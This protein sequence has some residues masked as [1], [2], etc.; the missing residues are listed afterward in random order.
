MVYRSPIA[1]GI[2]WYEATVAD[3]PEY[4]R[5]YGSRTADVAIVGGGFTGLQ[6]A[7]RLAE[8]G[9]DVVLID[10]ARFGDGASGR[11]GGQLGT[12]HRTWPEDHAQALGFAEAK[13]LFRL[14]EDAKAHLLDFARRH[15][16]EIDYR[17]GQMSVVHKSRYVDD[18]RRH[19]DVMA[20]RYDY[21]HIRFMDREETARRLGSDRYLAGIRDTGTGHI[22]PLKLLVGTARAAAQ[23]GAALH[24]HTP[25][26]EIRSERGRVS[27]ATPA[28]TIT[29]ERA[30]VA[31]NAYIGGLEPVTAAH[32]MPIRSFI[33]AT[34]P[35][36]ESLGVLPGGESV[37]DSRFVVRYFRRS[38][39]GRLLFGGREAYTAD[40]PRDISRHIG[41]QI[42]EL[43]PALAE[44]EITHA[45]GGSVG[46]TVPREPFVR[47]VMPGVTSIGGFSG[48]GVMLSNYTGR[49]YGES[50][51]G[52]RDLLEP[53]KALDIP[54]FPGG[55]RFAKP[56]L[57]LAMT[58]FALRDRF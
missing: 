38:I 40:N 26:T 19:A 5:L 56:L 4:G 10:A 3:R 16:I 44:V 50:L 49:L 51:L 47:E 9:A 52:N 58:W 11:N 36:E 7:C 23:A 28:G 8:G 43:Y 42:G 17:P 20:E 39:D 18:Y 25:A 27:V 22:H 15:A 12:G 55:R 32:V 46:I 57:L 54:R 21:P 53:L 41:R 34:V 1:P 29:A 45:W 2:S 14:A 48:H 31:C 35:L 13:A 33:G 6:A 37:D 30:L 24:E